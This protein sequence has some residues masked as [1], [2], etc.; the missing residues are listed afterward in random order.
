MR[1]RWLTF[2]RAIGADGPARALFETI[3]AM[4]AHPRRMY[5]NLD[6]I[7]DCL[8]VF[9]DV[10]G[11]EEPISL[12]LAI[13]LHD[14]IYEPGRPDNESMSA[15]VAVM[16]GRELGLSPAVVARVQDLILAT[17]HTAESEPGTG[18]AGLIADIDLSI[19]AAPPEAYDR[20]AAA[21]RVEFGFAPDEDYRKGRE[22]FLRA[23]LAKPEIYRTDIFRVRC[24]S[25]ARANIEREILGLEMK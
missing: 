5:H 8:D 23:L 16:F 21:I 24:E 7:R 19:L 12:E 15:E 1:E 14:C 10:G 2:C 18:D 11:A 22:A 3:E 13:W 17:R 9:D 25:K 4:Y 6:H 20:Y